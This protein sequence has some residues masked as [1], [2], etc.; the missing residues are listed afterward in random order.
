VIMLS[1]VGP[2]DE[3]VRALE[4]GADDYVVKPFG[5]RELVARVNAALRRVTEAPD[6]PLAC[7]RLTRA[8]RLSAAARHRMART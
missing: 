4:A 5:T 8:L 1:S 2:E 3:K 6:A 7:R